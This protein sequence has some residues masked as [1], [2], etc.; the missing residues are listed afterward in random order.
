MKQQLDPAR[1]A[2]ILQA[3]DIAALPPEQL[4]RLFQ[5]EP[6]IDQFLPDG[7][8]QVD[9]RNG[10][11][12][13]FNTSR[14]RRP[15][16]N[17][18]TPD[19]NANAFEQCVVCQ[20]KTT[21]VIDVAALSEGFTFINKNLFPMLY[22]AESRLTRQPPAI[23][24]ADRIEGAAAVG[25]HFLQWTS[26]LHDRDW[27]NMPLEDG[28]VAMQRLARLEKKLL[29]DCDQL[30][31]SRFPQESGDGAPG[32]FV[33]IIKNYGRLVGGS[34]AHGHQQIALSNVMPRRF[35]ENW[36]F[37]QNHGETFSAFMLRRNPADLLLLDY[38]PVQLIVP[39]FMRRPYDMLLLVKDIRIRYIHEL[40]AAGL[41]AVVQGWHDAIGAIR[42]IMPRVG[43]ELAYNVLV[44]NGPGA[45][46]YFE[47]LPY[48]QETGG[49]EHLGLAVCQSNPG[50]AASRLRGFFG[51]ARG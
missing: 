10:E 8:C 29:D 44:H 3:D 15:H 32:A 7:I 1:L 4:R 24:G 43:R 26:S 23:G 13:L 36:R 17:R 28:M 30:L 51:S 42:W 31:P 37:L 47:F 48:T 22:P 50:E 34:L 19:S 38:G 14:A 27:H 5:T 46:L 9:P 45:G 16:D 21:G 12:I 41:K 2:R 49:F 40:P 18:P 20:G 33:S 6:G 39:Y 35:K 25:Y 11:R